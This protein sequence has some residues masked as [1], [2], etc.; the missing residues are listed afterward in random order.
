MVNNN[1]CFI[2]VF[3]NDFA[4]LYFYYYYFNFDGDITKVKEINFNDMNIQNKMIRC[5]INSFSTFIMCFYYSID[6][7]Q[8]YLVSQIL[9][10]KEM[11]LEKPEV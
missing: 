6:N 3:N 2:I 7:E 9:N 10:M 11:N 4:N 1:I 5:Q 8:N